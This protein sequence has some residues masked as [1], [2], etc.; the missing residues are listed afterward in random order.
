MD[1]NNVWFI[2]K[3]R[4]VAQVFFETPF[5]ISVILIPGAA[6]RSLLWRIK[7]L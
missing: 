3:A 2:V 1:L 4:C 5:E 7:N 6:A